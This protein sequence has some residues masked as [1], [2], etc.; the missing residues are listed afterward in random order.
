MARNEIIKWSVIISISILFFT[1]GLFLGR[2]KVQA[3]GCTNFRLASC[4]SPIVDCDPVCPGGWKLV[5][6]SQGHPNDTLYI[7]LCAQ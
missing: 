5:S 2:S 6:K 1:T 3:Q 7:G 4:V